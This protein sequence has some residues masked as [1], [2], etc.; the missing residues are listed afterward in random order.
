[1]EGGVWPPDDRSAEMSTWVAPGYIGAP[2]DASVT[3]LD[4]VDLPL[5]PPQPAMATIATSNTA[6]GTSHNAFFITS[7]F[8]ITAAAATQAEI[9]TV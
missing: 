2:S 7:P 6:T 4:V 8:V 5:D 9:P 3:L 1:M